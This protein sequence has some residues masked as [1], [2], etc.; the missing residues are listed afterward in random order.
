[1]QK[2]DPEPD[3]KAA[4]AFTSIPPWGI[5]RGV[6]RLVGD[7][8]VQIPPEGTDVNFKGKS[9]TGEKALRPCIF[10]SRKAGEIYML[11]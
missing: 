8:K 4:G 1:M 5:R 2:F 9:E 3:E 7:G 6:E 11:I 10:N